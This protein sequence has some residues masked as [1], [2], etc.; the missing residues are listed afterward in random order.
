MCLALFC[1]AR[2]LAQMPTTYSRVTHVDRANGTVLVRAGSDATFAGFVRLSHQSLGDSSELT[3]QDILEANPGKIIYVC[4]LPNGTLARSRRASTHDLCASRYRQYWLVQGLTYVVQAPSLVTN[5]VGSAAPVTPSLQSAVARLQHMV[6]IRDRIIERLHSR[7]SASQTLGA[8]NQD[9]TEATETRAEGVTLL[10]GLLAGLGLAFLF[11]AF[12]RWRAGRLQRQTLDKHATLLKKKV[13]E[14]VDELR[15]LRRQNRRLVN[16][17]DKHIA[18]VRQ[19]TQ[20]LADTSETLRQRDTHIEQLNDRL[21]AP[22]LP[23]AV[24][25]SFGIDQGE[26]PSITRTQEGA[27][28]SSDDAFKPSKK[29]DQEL[30]IAQLQARILTLEAQLARRRQAT[31]RIPKLMNELE[32]LKPPTLDRLYSQLRTLQRCR[33]TALARAEA[34]DDHVSMHR[35]ELLTISLSYDSLIKSTED[36]IEAFESSEEGRRSAELREELSEL[37]MEVTG[38]YTTTASMEASL[39]RDRNKADALYVNMLGER[40][41]FQLLQ[42][43]FLARLPESTR[44]PSAESERDT[45]IARLEGRLLGTERRLMEQMASLKTQVEEYEGAADEQNRELTSK[46]EDLRRQLSES[47]VRE[48]ELLNDNATLRRLDMNKRKRAELFWE[49]PESHRRPTRDTEQITRVPS[50]Q[51]PIGKSELI[52]FSDA[53]VKLVDRIDP[54]LQGGRFLPMDR[55]SVVDLARLLAYA[56]VEN[57]FYSGEY[58]PLYLLS[59]HLILQNG[60]KMP[61]RLRSLT[62][63]PPGTQH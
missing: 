44:T 62:M 9:L 4:R 25:E 54:S 41:A 24:V 42:K 55:A 61:D 7:G 35:R 5:V 13:R 6:A 30:L 3:R 18:Q 63:R 49:E 58:I 50:V 43:E 46:L 37:F 45:V 26:L 20:T 51:R 31:E 1:P 23:E 53:I 29:S 52:R 11:F 17:R 22:P 56:K 32:S 2:S 39:E 16:A 57:P 15:L 28:T 33:D 12:D 36:E 8:T 21:N 19:L 27:D 14:Q 10:V 47:H 48:S 60:G 59:N 38:I 34:M 40:K